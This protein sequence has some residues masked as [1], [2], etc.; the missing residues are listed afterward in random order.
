MRGVEAEVIATER[1][2][3]LPLAAQYAEEMAE[4]L[5][6]SRLHDFI[7]GTP[8]TPQGLRARYERLVAGSGDA[9]VSWCNWV[10]RLESA[11]C[12][13]GTVQAT[14][15]GGRAEIA[16]VVGT[17]WQGQG[18]ATEAARGLVGW[19]CAQGVTTLVAHI[20]PDHLAS[21]AV[22]AGAGLTATDEWDDGERR[23]RL[24]AG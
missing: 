9:A 4:V 20:H 21:A 17:P 6:D 13:T 16:W 23:W 19:L 8:Q 10:V 7:G 3:L 22:A 15:V 11:D 14:V 5:G 2:T 12:L 18:I 24:I 1:L